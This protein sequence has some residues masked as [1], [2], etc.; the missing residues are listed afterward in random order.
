[1]LRVKGDIP[2]ILYPEKLAFIY[3]GNRKIISNMPALKKCIIHVLFL[4][5]L[6]KDRLMQSRY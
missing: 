6:F 2:R 3:E 1:M 4:K 5:S